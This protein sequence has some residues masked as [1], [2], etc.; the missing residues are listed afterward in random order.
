MRLPSKL[1]P[2]YFSFRFGFDINNRIAHTHPTRAY[3]PKIIN[4]I[5]LSVKQMSFAEYGFDTLT[6]T[7]IEQQQNKQ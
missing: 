6:T 5:V 7:P 4:E 3:N 2:F 1:D